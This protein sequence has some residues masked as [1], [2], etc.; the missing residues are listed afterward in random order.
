MMDETRYLAVPIRLGTESETL[1][2]DCYENLSGDGRPTSVHL[3]ERAGRVRCPQCG[4]EEATVEASG[5]ADGDD[6]A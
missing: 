1:C 3:R 2:P 4:W 5:Q 6:G